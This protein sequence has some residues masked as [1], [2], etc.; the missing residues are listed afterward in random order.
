MVGEVSNHVNEYF[1]VS[2]A[3]TLYYIIG[4]EMHSKRAVLK[5]MYAS[6]K[7]NKL[8]IISNNYFHIGNLKEVK[9]KST[10]TMH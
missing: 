5:C 4:F 7:K 2:H 10:Y 8:F 6:K 3:C 1:D 9:L